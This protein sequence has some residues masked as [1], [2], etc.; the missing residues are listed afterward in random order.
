MP[1]KPEPVVVCGVKITNPDRVVYKLE[2]K[3]LTKLDV[4]RYIERV[5]PLMLPHV[6]GRPISVVRCRDGSDGPGFFQKHVMKGMPAQIHSM[7]V[8]EKKGVMPNLTVHDAA[9]LV[10]LVQMSALEFHSWCS[11]E[12]DTNAPDRLIIDLD[13]G[14]DLPWSRVCDAARTSRDL[15]SADGIESFVKTTGGK[16]LHV[17][18]PLD[19]TSWHSLTQYVEELATTMMEREP[20]QYTLNM[21]KVLRAGKIFIDIGRN[22]PGSTVIAPWSMRKSG[23]VSVPIDWNEID[24]VRGSTWN[25]VTV[26]ERLRTH[27]DAPWR[28]FFEVRQRIPNDTSRR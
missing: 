26:D 10:G 22:F 17:V 16:G 7:D 28:R 2:G 13:P 24:D 6:S 5:A 20:D 18:A 15:L 9:G 3:S 14:V 4:A 21:K 12:D 19:A 23:T 25:L 27:G 8:V 11:K 1:A